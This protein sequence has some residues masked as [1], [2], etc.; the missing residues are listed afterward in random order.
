MSVDKELNV[1][2]QEFERKGPKDFV[3]FM[4]SSLCID[5]RFVIVFGGLDTIQRKP[6]DT[7]YVIDVLKREW[8][9]SE[10]TLPQKCRLS[11]ALLSPNQQDIH[12]LGGWDEKN[13]RMN[14]HW[15]MS[16]SS[17]IPELK[18]EEKE[19]RN[20]MKSLF[21]WKRNA[22]S[23]HC[24]HPIMDEKWPHIWTWDYAIASW[25]VQCMHS[26]IW[27]SS[28]CRQRF[29][30]HLFFGQC[31]D[32]IFASLKLWKRE[33]APRNAW[34]KTKAKKIFPYPHN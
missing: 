17:L 34:N 7:I 10:M 14:N 19:K 15:I 13:Q 9:K 6:V 20:A 8:I 3:C 2:F 18:R 27:W 30:L 31:G 32:G 26:K 28:N 24:F 12:L 22:L 25:S 5:R 29:S 21:T 16:V 11:L 33:V 4:S 1:S 23:C